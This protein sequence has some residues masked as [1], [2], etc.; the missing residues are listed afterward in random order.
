M[1]FKPNSH[2][3]F[4]QRGIRNKVAAIKSFWLFIDLRKYLCFAVYG[5]KKSQSWRAQGSDR[6]GTTQYSKKPLIPT[7]SQPAH[8]GEGA[9]ATVAHSFLLYVTRTVGGWMDDCFLSS[10]FWY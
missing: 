8:P 10:C 1:K 3:L 9:A 6:M 7:K 2:S 5:K 4:S